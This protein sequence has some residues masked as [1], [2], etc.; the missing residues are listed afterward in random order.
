[1]S[2]VSETLQRG[3]R[4]LDCHSDSPRLDAE[5]L[6][7]NLLGLSR[8]GLIARGNEPVTLERERAYAKLIERRLKGAPVAYLTGT[9][10]FWSLLLK[11]TPA[12]L[13]PRPETELLVELALGLLPEHR[14]C[15]SAD[16]ACS[17]LDLGTGS[18]A[19]ALAIAS[20][21]PRSR[22][23][24]VDISPAALDVA[25]QNSRDLGL[26]HIE[27]RLGSWFEAVPGERFDLIVANPPYVAA[28]DPALE[29]LRAE[30]AIALC[31]G[32]TG[33]EALSEIAGGAAAHLHERGWL[34]LEHGS[35]QAPDVAQLLEHHGFTSIRA[36][37]D[38]SGK[39]RVT[40]GTLHSPH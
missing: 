34:L 35:D 21:R 30:P 28:A 36:H 10:E 26:A 33:L 7:G 19:I 37:L 39:P 27:W 14:A 8:P 9:R 31:V 22:L 3:V 5:L 11:V 38:F 4:S 17:V 25:I 32:P 29:K 13:V 20:E 12:V 40:L 2:T 16:Q 23:M 1:V 18:G 15:P 6:L 24:G